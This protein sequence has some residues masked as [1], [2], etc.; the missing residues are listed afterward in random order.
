LAAGLT[1]WA[2]TGCASN[3]SHKVHSYDQSMDEDKDPTFRPDP[4]RADEEVRQ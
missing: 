1:L 4:E 3:K 2:L